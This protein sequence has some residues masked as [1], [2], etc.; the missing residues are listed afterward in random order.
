MDEKIYLFIIFPHVSMS[1]TV[2][3]K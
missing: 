2:I 3:Y 1:A